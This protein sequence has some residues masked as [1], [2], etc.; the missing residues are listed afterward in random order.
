MRD[1]TYVFHKSVV[2]LWKGGSKHH[3]DIHWGFVLCASKLA[4]G[5]DPVPLP[6]QDGGTLHLIL[7]HLEA[8]AHLEEK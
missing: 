7:Y 6:G 8:T 3:C 5:T 1:F 4:P 2:M